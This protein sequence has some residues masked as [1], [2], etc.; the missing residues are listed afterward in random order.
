MP[1]LNIHSSGRLNVPVS[2]VSADRGGGGGAEFAVTQIN[3]VTT[4][5]PRVY[6]GNTVFTEILP[7]S[8]TRN[9]SPSADRRWESP[10]RSV[11]D[12]ATMSGRQVTV[13]PTLRGA[14]PT[15]RLTVRQAEILRLTAF[16][17]AGKQIARYLGISVRTVEGHF[18]VMRQRTGTRSQAELIAFAIATGLVTVDLSRDETLPLTVGSRDETR[19]PAVVSTQCQVCGKPLA[20]AST[21]RPRQYCSRACQ[22]RAYRSRK[23]EPALDENPTRSLSGKGWD[24]MPGKPLPADVPDRDQIADLKRRI[25]QLELEIAY[26]KKAAAYCAR[27]HR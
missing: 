3:A 19:H 18:E 22:A 20:A 12:G 2:G 13:Q 23:Q 27:E 9:V 21:G 7:M 8:N 6:R 16:G 26:L 14:D 24:R 4:W 10:E 25:H 5:Q 15:I 11:R 1:K 17:L